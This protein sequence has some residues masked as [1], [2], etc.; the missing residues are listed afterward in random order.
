LDGLSFIELRDI[1][2]YF[3]FSNISKEDFWQGNLD[4]CVAV[5]AQETL[6]ETSDPP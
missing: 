5:T 1:I 3:D 2:I 6:E 4:I